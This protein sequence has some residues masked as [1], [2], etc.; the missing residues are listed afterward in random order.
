M[1][2]QEI[3]RYTL[4]PNQL[5]IDIEAQLDDVDFDL[6]PIVALD[7]DTDNAARIDEENKP[8]HPT[9]EAIL[10][11]DKGNIH[12]IC[13]KKLEYCRIRKSHDETVSLIKS[14]GDA[15][16]SAALLMPLPILTIASYCVMSLY[17]D[18]ICECDP[19]D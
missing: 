14:V 4:D 3:E 8:I 18:R 6:F 9:L 13:C 16:I 19:S 1:N 12:K 17:L 11:K 10:E 5:L 7:A 2:V 15:F